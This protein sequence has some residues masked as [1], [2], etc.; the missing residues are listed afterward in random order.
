MDKEKERAAN[1]RSVGYTNGQW[2]HK[3][4]THRRHKSYLTENKIIMLIGGRNVEGKHK[5][6]CSVNRDPLNLMNQQILEYK[7]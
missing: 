6:E 1:C 3:H 4:P 7:Q 5:I 2:S